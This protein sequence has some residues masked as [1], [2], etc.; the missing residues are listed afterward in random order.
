MDR[1]EKIR[2]KRANLNAQA[3]READERVRKVEYYTN[4]IKDLAPRLNELY[5][6]ARECVKNQIPLGNPTHLHG[7]EHYPEF[8]SEWWWHKPGFVVSFKPSIDE[9]VYFGIIGGGCDGHDLVI[10]YNGVI[11]K[12]PINHVVGCW[13]Y[14]NAHWDFCD[15]C[16]RFLDCFDKFEKGFLDYIDNLS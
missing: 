1:L 4:K 11:V 7:D 16:K 6:I 5:V 3:Q 9:E 13:T 8:V 15:K 14:E 12:N 10:D 2:A